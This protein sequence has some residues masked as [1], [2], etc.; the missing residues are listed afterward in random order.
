RGHQA[1][2]PP[3]EKRSAGHSPRRCSLCHPAQMLAI[4]VGGKAYRLAGLAQRQARHIARLLAA[5]VE[6]AV[7]GVRRQLGAGLAVGPEHLYQALGE[8]LLLVEAPDLSLAAQVPVVLPVV[9]KELE[10]GAH[11]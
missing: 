2:E 11:V 6:D 1:C 3:A 10:V 8:D 5:T 9:E 7:D 4:Q